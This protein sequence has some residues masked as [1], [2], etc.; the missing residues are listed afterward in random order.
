MNFH[1]YIIIEIQVTILILFLVYFFNKFLIFRLFLL[2]FHD[3][4]HMY[5]LRVNNNLILLMSYILNI[6]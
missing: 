6:F 3:N 4:Y 1:I 2:I 5:I